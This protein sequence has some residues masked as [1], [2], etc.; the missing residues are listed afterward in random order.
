MAT[1]SVSAPEAV[2]AFFDDARR[3]SQ[4]RAQREYNFA[5]R[6]RVV[7]ELLAATRFERL[8]DFGCGSGGYLEVVQEF[9]CEYFGLDFAESMIA[10]ARE[11]AAELRVSDRSHLETGQVEA[12]PYPDAH[13]DVVIGIGLIE[14]FRD[15][16]RLMA[17]IRRTLRPGGHLILQSYLPNAW[18]DSVRRGIRPLRRLLGR[19]TAGIERRRYGKRQLDDLLASSGFDLVDYGFSNFFLLPEPFASYLPGLHARFSEFAGRTNPRA[20]RHLAVNY[21]GKYQLRRS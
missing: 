2:Q 19:E 6:R 20:F 15:P 3:V 7:F 9:G 18:V 4:F 12:T 16:G 1:H 13:F 10:A 21:I 5:S 14:Y 11:R 17:E 8:A